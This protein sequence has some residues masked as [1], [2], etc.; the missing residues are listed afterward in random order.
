MSSRIF[1]TFSIVLLVLGRPE[2]SSSSTDAQPVL[3]LE[4]HSKTAAQLKERSPKSHEA[5]QGFR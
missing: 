1:S 5:F 4:C 2:R 3:K